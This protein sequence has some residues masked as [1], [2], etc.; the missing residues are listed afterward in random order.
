MKKMET[1]FHEQR[2]FK[3]DFS[4]NTTKP[5]IVGNVD[6]DRAEIRIISP[7]SQFRSVGSASDRWFRPKI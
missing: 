2:L 7:H 3:S 5:L 6:P 1:N 4:L